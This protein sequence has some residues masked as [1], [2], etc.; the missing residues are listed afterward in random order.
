[1][2]SIFPGSIKRQWRNNN[3]L[4]GRDLYNEETNPIVDIFSTAGVEERGQNDGPKQCNIIKKRKD[5]IAI[6][7]GGIFF[8]GPDLF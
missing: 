6:K 1:M 5:N 2:C 4:Y 8:T 7:A 3:H